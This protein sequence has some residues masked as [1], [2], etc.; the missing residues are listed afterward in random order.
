MCECHSR[1][2]KIKYFWNARRKKLLWINVTITSN[3]MLLGRYDNCSEGFYDVCAWSTIFLVI[4]PYVAWP[5]PH[6]NPIWYSV[7]EVFFN[8]FHFFFL[9]RC[10]PTDR[11]AIIVFGRWLF[12]S[13]VSSVGHLHALTYAYDDSPSSPSPPPRTVVYAAS[14][15][16]KTVRCVERI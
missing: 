11:Y 2:G 5:Y 8:F 1:T 14:S 7:V 10:F 15:V 12:F 4:H 13:L 16:H 9:S 3:S 6:R